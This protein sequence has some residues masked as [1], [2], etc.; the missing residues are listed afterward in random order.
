MKF[1]HHHRTAILK[2]LSE[3]GFEEL[4]FDFVK[5]RGRIHIRFK[6][7]AHQFSYL[8]VKETQLDQN[9]QWQEMESFK[10][11]LDQHKEYP[12]SDWNQVMNAFRQWL[13]SI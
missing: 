8:R 1:V 12:V 13:S 6:Y 10:I 4:D 5:K 7:N 2:A 11:K 9:L 3:E